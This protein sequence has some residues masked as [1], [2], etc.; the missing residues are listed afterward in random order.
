MR[1][2]FP[3]PNRARKRSA[4]RLRAPAAPRRMLDQEIW[5]D[6]GVWHVRAPI[7]VES[8]NANGN[9]YARAA[10]A[11]KQIASTLLLLRTNLRAVDRDAIAGVEFVRVSPGRLDAHD[12]LPQAFKHVCDA[13]C[14]WILHGPNEFNRRGIGRCDDQLIGTGRLRCVYSQMTIGNEHGIELRLRLTSQ[15]SSTVEQSS[16]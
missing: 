13:V 4:A 15:R 1:M 7:R 11:D 2:T 16:S 14:A 10:A 9:R 5:Y 8:D 6:A 12:N 3:P